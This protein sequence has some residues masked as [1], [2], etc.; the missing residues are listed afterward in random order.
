[1]D[2]IQLVMNMDTIASFAPIHKPK[3]FLPSWTNF[4]PAC[5]LSRFPL[6]SFPGKPSKL[7][8]LKANTITA[9]KCVDQESNRTFHKVPPSQWDWGQHF[10]SVHVDVTEMDAL[11]IEIEELKPIVRGMLMSS[12]SVDSTKKRVCLIYLLV[13][14][15]LMYLFED[16]IE[17]SLQENFEKIE[18]VLAGENDCPRFPT[19]FG[20]SEHTVT[21]C[22]LVFTRFKGEDG[23][24]KE[25]LVED[26]KGMVSFYE[27]AH[28]G[29]TTEDIMDEALSFTTSKLESLAKYGDGFS[30]ITARIKNALCMPQ[31]FNNEMVFTREYI[32]FYENEEDHNKMLLRFAKINFRFLQQNWIQELTT[33]GRWWK[34]QDY[35]SKLPPYFRDR[36][37]ECYLYSL[38]TYFEPRFSRGR[39][40]ILNISTLVTLID[41]TCDRYAPLSDIADLVA[42]VERWDP[43]NLDCLPDYMKIVFKAAWDILEKCESEG[44][45]EEGSSFDVQGLLGE[46]KIYLR[47]NLRF[48]EW[49]QTDLVPTTLD[50]YF[51]IGGTEVTMHISVGGT[52]LALGK[53]D[54]DKAY[55]WLKSRPKYIQA[56][57]KRGRLMNDITG[58]YDDMSRGY[59]PNAVNYYM[60]QYN[61][62][63]DEALADLHMMVRELDKTVNEEFLKTAKKMPR[64][65]LR[66]PIG[67]GNTVVFS[68]RFGEEFTFPERFKEH[69]TSLFVNLIPL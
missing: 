61:V 59:K 33:L 27:A 13:S 18:D 21:K 44:K 55:E 34:Q 50:E 15:G 64:K 31:H 41:D 43:D 7:V 42:C 39:A 36:L 57:A 24:F 16:E 22:L 2:S 45:S 48:A 56:Q 47:A 51:E 49:A 67:F 35:A 20:F 54:R 1:M 9:P 6:I 14:L 10:L 58:F 25:C 28:L 23:K 11:R 3:H 8:R 30:H 65:I 19:S 37:T 69:I 66:G 63:E 17:K 29:T 4:F 46:L 12:Q 26:V 68:Y 60:K 52:F 5:K 62:T 32:T 38:L 53:T 40:A